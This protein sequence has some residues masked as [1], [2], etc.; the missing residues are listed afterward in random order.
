MKFYLRI[1]PTDSEN[2][3]DQVA[4]RLGV[5]L[6]GLENAPLVQAPES[7]VHGGYGVFFECAVSDQPVLLETL[8]L[9]GFYVCM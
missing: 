5:I 9:E 3:L 8:K 1:I 2:S 4:F 6:E 7:H